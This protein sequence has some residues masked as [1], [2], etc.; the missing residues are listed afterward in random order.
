VVL[1]G[2]VSARPFPSSPKFLFGVAYP[3]FALSLGPNPGPEDGGKGRRPH[4]RLSLS[5]SGIEVVC[6]DCRCRLYMS[7][8]YHVW[9]GK[10]RRRPVFFVLISDVKRVSKHQGE[11]RG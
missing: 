11:I 2:R 5:A 10:Y 8:F 1:V 3:H 7:V 6:G 4:S 9:K